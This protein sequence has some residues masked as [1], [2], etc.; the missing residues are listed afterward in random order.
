[1][2]FN[3]AKVVT[4]PFGPHKGKLIGELGMTEAGVSY[5]SWLRDEITTGSTRGPLLSALEAY[6]EHDSIA[7]ALRAV[8]RG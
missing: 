5:L 1:V 6:L 8:T 4:I 7:G 2:T 3:E